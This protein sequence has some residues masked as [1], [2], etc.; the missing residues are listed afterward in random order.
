MGWAVTGHGSATSAPP[1]I[2][3]LS[4]QGGGA[5]NKPQAWF[6][7]FAKTHGGAAYAGAGRTLNNAR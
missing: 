7:E 5:P 6:L 2:P 1:P 4:L 3:A